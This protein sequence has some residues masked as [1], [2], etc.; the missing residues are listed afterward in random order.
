VFELIS[1]VVVSSY[2]DN[3]IK[4]VMLL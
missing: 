2:L 1:T 3:V 4:T